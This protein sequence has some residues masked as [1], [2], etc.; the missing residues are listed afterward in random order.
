MTEFDSENC[1]SLY[2][3]IINPFAFK[4]ITKEEALNRLK[5]IQVP[6]TD[7]APVDV[8]KVLNELLTVDIK[9]KPVEEPK[10]KKKPIFKNK[11]D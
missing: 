6:K 11:E 2:Y 8:K 1:R 10:S 5:N 4:H 7:S 9:E 3:D